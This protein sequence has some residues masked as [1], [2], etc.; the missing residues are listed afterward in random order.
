[1]TNVQPVS[2]AARPFPPRAKRPGTG[3]PQ[4]RAGRFRRSRFIAVMKVLLP[5][6]AVALLALVAAWPALELG[7][8]RFRLDFALV[9]PPTAAEPQMLNPRLLSID[10][11]Q[12]PLTLTADMA[13]QV[14]GVGESDMFQLSEPKADIML[15]DGTWWALSASE[16][17]FQ[18]DANVLDLTG[19]VSLF[20]DSGYEFGTE[21]VR[22]FLD[23]RDVVGDQTIRGHGPFGEIQAEG[24]RIIDGGGRMLFTGKSKLTIFGGLK[25]P[26]G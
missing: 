8:D 16:G 20:H 23:R 13:T 5:G 14:S 26:A 15:D 24:F 7:D 17:L 25:P 2:P 1:M 12:Q 19:A 6:A 3:A 10:A 4:A 9:A 22:I 18:R 21:T 11:R